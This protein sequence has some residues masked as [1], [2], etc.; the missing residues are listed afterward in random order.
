MGSFSINLA[1]QAVYNSQAGARDET[2][3]LAFLSS[4]IDVV[5]RV[6]DDPL[7]REAA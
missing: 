2:P 7:R 6:S 5:R 1:S 4:G 3:S